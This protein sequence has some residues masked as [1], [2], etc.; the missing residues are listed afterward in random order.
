MGVEGVA[1]FLVEVGGVV[2]AGSYDEGAPFAYGEAHV[3]AEL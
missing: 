3:G 1:V 2:A